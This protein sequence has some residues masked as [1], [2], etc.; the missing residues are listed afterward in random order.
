ML[1]ADCE[2]LVKVSVAVILASVFDV[3]VIVA[4]V[5]V[6]PATLVVVV[7]DTVVVGAV[8]HPSGSA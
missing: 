1:V 2:V 5:D 6:A 4:L 3:L 8:V 7:L